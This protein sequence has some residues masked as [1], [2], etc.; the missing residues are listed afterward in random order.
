MM[1]GTVMPM[2]KLFVF[3]MKSC[4]VFYLI[5]VLGG[6]HSVSIVFIGAPRQSHVMGLMGGVLCASA[7]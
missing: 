1:N 2:R 7:S 6:R 3:V 4:L 5:V